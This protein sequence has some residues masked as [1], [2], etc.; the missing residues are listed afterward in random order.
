ML[1][2]ASKIL[3][4]TSM[5]S[6]QGSQLPVVGT[7]SSAR[8]QRSYSIKFFLMQLICIDIIMIFASP[9]HSDLCYIEG[10][11]LF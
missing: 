11:S 1:G 6:A 3:I 7:K 4:L 5:F 9:S 8:V 10:G 2:S